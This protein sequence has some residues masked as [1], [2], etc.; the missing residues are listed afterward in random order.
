MAR[1]SSFGPFRSLADKAWRE[2]R[3]SGS[4]EGGAAIPIEGLRAS[5]AAADAT[6]QALA[7]IGKQQTPIPVAR[8]LQSLRFGLD[9]ATQLLR[10]LHSL[11]K[12]NDAIADAQEHYMPGGPPMSPVLDT[13]FSTWM[14]FD[15]RRGRARESV[16][17]IISAIIRKKGHATHPLLLRLEQFMASHWAVYT[18]TRVSSSSECEVRNILTGEDLRVVH[19][20]A[21]SIKLGDQVLWRLLAPERPGEAWI[22][23]LS[24]YLI[25]GVRVRDWQMYAERV[26]GASDP[27]PSAVRNLFSTADAERRWLDYLVD[28][29]LGVDPLGR[30]TLTGVPDRP[31]S[32][33]HS[34][35]REASPD[36]A[37]ADARCSNPDCAGPGPQSRLLDWIEANSSGQMSKAV[38]TMMARLPKHLRPAA[39]ES[40]DMRDFMRSVA[41]FSVG[42]D[43]RSLADVAASEAGAGL[44]PSLRACLDLHN[45]SPAAIYEMV[46]MNSGSYRLQDCVTL[47]QVDLA[48]SPWPGNPT[49]G[50]VLAQVVGPPGDRQLAASCPFVVAGISRASLVMAITSKVPPLSHTGVSKTQHNAMSRALIRAFFELLE[51]AIGTSPGVEHDPTDIGDGWYAEELRIPAESRKSILAELRASECTSAVAGTGTGKRGNPSFA[52]NDASGRVLGWIQVRRS[53]IEICTLEDHELGAVKAWVRGLTPGSMHVEKRKLV[54]VQSPK[55]T[56]SWIR[57]HGPWALQ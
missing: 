34:L 29:Y 49:S 24:A 57:E 30:V 4:G 14:L 25:S 48:N 13:A 40:P 20:H 32:L 31:D 15:L 36:E 35:D 27:S 50:F 6:H 5:R 33:P 8:A 51:R 56:R 11:R 9:I 46:G 17:D 45:H 21:L 26:T 52:W 23:A 3:K 42:P 22:G 10:Q 28:G 41:A 43:N 2:M 55:T 12:L 44:E 16:S 54:R 19:D 1:S 38:D 18:C 47:E 53:F 37:H 7:E 39:D